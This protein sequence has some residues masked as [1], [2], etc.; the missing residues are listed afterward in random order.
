[1][2]VWVCHVASGSSCWLSRCSNSGFIHSMLSV[3]VVHGFR[4][5]SREGA[6]DAVMLLGKSSDV[7]LPILGV[8]VAQIVWSWHLSSYEGQ[9]GG[10]CVV[11]SVA[12]S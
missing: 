8:W 5:V 9:D 2:F 4:I 7:I 12:K 10:G 1:M 11:R 6:L 3:E